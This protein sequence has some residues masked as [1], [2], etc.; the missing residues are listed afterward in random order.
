M[1]RESEDHR[2]SAPIIEGGISH[3]ERAIL[4]AVADGR[5]QMMSGCG[6]DLTIDGAWCDHLAAQH[7]L[8]AGLIRPVG[9]SEVGGMV[10][11]EI[12]AH[13]ARVLA[14]AETPTAVLAG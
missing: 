8:E 9:T 14:V 10:P 7:L 4:R 5:A 13:G 3:R 6:H 2:G 12:T 1:V 11:V